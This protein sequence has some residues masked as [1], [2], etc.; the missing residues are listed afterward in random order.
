M[1]GAALLQMQA[2]PEY[3]AAAAMVALGVWLLRL[4]IR[5]PTNVAFASFLLARAAS[6]YVFTFETLLEADPASPAR[7]VLVW[8]R[9][10]PLFIIATVFTLLLFLV[11]HTGRAMPSRRLRALRWTVLAA[12]LATEAAY[13]ARPSLWATYEFS[14]QADGTESLQFQTVGPFFSL[15][16]LRVLSFGVAALVFA[17]AHRRSAAGAN[18]DSLLL[19]FA[20]FA[21]H[22]VFDGTDALALLASAPAGALTGWTRIQV[23]AEVANL[24]P[25]A[26]AAVLIGSARLDAPGE[27][28]SV[29][30][31]LIALLFP[32]ATNLLVFG[33]VVRG[34][35][36]ANG[37]WSLFFL[38]LWRLSLPLLAT[39]A[40]VKHRLFGIDVRVKRTL[41]RTIV[42]IV[43]VI[44]FFAV[45]EGA[46]ALLVGHAAGPAIGI[47]ATALLTFA[48]FPLQRLAER[49]ADTAMPEVRAVSDLDR[50]ERRALYRALARSAIASGVVSP[51]EAR[52]LAVARERL[53]LSL[54]ESQTIDAEERR[55]AGAG[56]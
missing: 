5:D 7:D 33:L 14:A 22:A 50:H 43:F 3:I 27:E 18:R 21:L 34:V 38:G 36:P 4:N 25:V 12:F 37:P 42:A 41:Q 48:I 24:L 20:A 28:R 40:L 8:E 2:M 32:A 56:P 17:L 55:Q 15:Q 35:E 44:V 13:V 46:E 1:N 16:I 31:A 9:L 45:S 39:Y 23:I 52:L 11:L 30:R 6:M 47:L 10:R 19:F 29:R 26:L 53:G 54:E 51:D 49:L